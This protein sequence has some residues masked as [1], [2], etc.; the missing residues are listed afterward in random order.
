MTTACEEGHTVNRLQTDGLSAGLAEFWRH[1]HGGT[2]V[3]ARVCVGQDGRVRWRSTR[4][5]HMPET[6]ITKSGPPG[7][8]SPAPHGGADSADFQRWRKGRRW[9]DCVMAETAVCGGGARG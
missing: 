1:P 3:L 5:G 8:C 4:L 2:G 7:L 9:L 6:S